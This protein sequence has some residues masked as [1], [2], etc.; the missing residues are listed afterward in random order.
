MT[1]GLTVFFHRTLN[2]CQCWVSF[3]NLWVFICAKW[4]R[5][6][7]SMLKCKFSHFYG[8]FCNAA[9]HKTQEEKSSVHLAHWK[10]SVE[11]TAVFKNRDRTLVQL[12]KLRLLWWKTSV[13]WAEKFRCSMWT[14]L[15]VTKLFLWVREN[16][17]A[18]CGKKPCENV[19]KSRGT[20][21]IRFMCSKGCSF[22]ICR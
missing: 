14:K 18:L 22:K 20:M 4:C 17:T 9:L 12:T 3:W 8:T 16:L 19:F 7:L 13:T 1:C 5:I 11:V 2:F 21:C 15:A 10:F 6:S